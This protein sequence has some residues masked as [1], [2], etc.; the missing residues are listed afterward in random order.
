MLLQR[1]SCVAK[2]VISTKSIGTRLI[3][4]YL[5]AINISE[6]RVT[7]AEPHHSDHSAVWLAGTD[8]KR[9][10]LLNFILIAQC[11]QTGHLADKL[12]VY[13]MHIPLRRQLIFL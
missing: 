1:S 6:L 4:Y 12:T 5:R 3:L 7:S 11:K 2:L 8:T 9:E 10:V 13:N